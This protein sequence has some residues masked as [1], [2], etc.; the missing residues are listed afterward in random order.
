MTEAPALLVV[1]ALPIESQG[2]FE[3]EGVPVLFTGLGKVN[4]AIGLARSLA[5][6]RA[7]GQALPRVVNFGTAGSRHFDTGA[8]VA[9]HRF[10]QRDMDVSAL[11]FP[12]G[13]TPFEHLPAQLEF[14]PMFPDLPAGLCGSGDSFQT[15]AQRLHCEVI[16]MEAYAFAKACLVEGADFGCAKYITDGADHAAASDWQSNLPRAAERFWELYRRL[17]SAAVYNGS[18]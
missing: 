1:M 4:A 10:V 15:G 8:L 13:H 11:G 12:L 7:S 2:V 14:P 6:Y 17:A 18:S 5:A 3:R 9:C 16:D